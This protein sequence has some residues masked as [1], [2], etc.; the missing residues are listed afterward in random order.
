MERHQLPTPQAGGKVQEKQLIV[1]LRL[2]LDEKPLQFLP[3]QHLH[4]PRLLGR[5]LTADGGIG[6][7]QPLLHRLFQRG[8]AGGV[9]HSDHSIGQSL[10]V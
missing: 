2:S 10:A 4:L 1:A 3:V 8:A 6:A 9:A 5:Q 7:N